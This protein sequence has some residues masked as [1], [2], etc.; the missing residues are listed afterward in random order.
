MKQAIVAENLIMKFGNFSAVN[1]VSFI[2]EK[3]EIFGLLG[4]NGSGK[5]TIIKVLCGLL[6]PSSGSAN[7]LGLNVLKHADTLKERIGNMSQKFS[8]YGD[9][10]VD[11]NIEFYADIYD[12]KGAY[13]QRR[14][15]EVVALLGLSDFL[16]KPSNVLSGGWKQRLAL[17]C[18]IIHKPEILFLDE[19][20]A[21][22]DPVAR[23]EI[24]DLLFRLSAQ[25]MTLFI[26]THYMDEAERCGRVAYVYY[27]K[28]IACGTPAELKQLPAV[29]P[30]N[31]LRLQVTCP[32]PSSALMYIRRLAY[33]LEATIFGEAIHVLIDS[34][35]PYQRL[36]EDLAKGGFG[37]A[38]V[39]P[40]NPTLEDAFVSLTNY[41]N[42]ERGK[43]K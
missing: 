13:L 8:L 36:I 27:S 29:S 33:V 28:M 42:K 6:L 7:I 18:A 3:G 35:K 26:T 2:V 4:P 5:T 16:H 37:I 14:R 32:A 20:T 10:T 43:E 30:D 22:I 1:N 23:R 25:G 39:Q 34:S 38:T 19:P 11:E 12:L 9:L 24:W 15:E 40:I 31:T 17:A 41:I 21:G